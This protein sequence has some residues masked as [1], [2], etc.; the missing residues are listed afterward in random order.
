MFRS[1]DP[2]LQRLDHLS[3]KIDG[4]REEL[5]SWRRLAHHR[6]GEI[7]RLRERLQEYSAAPPP[8]APAP[9]KP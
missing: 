9:V 4:L 3:N 7:V 8:A 2:L 5:E 1:P 6:A